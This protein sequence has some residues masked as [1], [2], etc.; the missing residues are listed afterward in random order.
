MK[1]PSSNRAVVSYRS[2][3]TRHKTGDSVSRDVKITSYGALLKELHRRGLVYALLRDHPDKPGMRDLD[4]VIDLAQRQAFVACCEQNGFRLLKSG[5]SNPGKLVMLCWNEAGPQIIDVHERMIYQGYEYLNVKT[6]LARRRQEGQY[7]FLSYEDELLALL[8]HNILGKGEIQQKHRGR[9][10]ELLRLRLDEDYLA[11]HLR[12]F[13]L[14]EILSRARKDFINLREDAKA[15]KRL[16]RA[17][18]RA[19]RFKPASNAARRVRMFLFGFWEKWLGPRR[20]ALIVFVGPDG[21]GK[22]SITSALRRE[23]RSATITTDIVY[24]GPWGQYKLPFIKILNALHIKPYRPED[25]A[26]YR[27][28]KIEL[29]T[30][31]AFSRFWRDVKGRTFYL[32]L[33]AELWFRYVVLVLPKLRR[34][35][36]VLADR[37]VYDILIGYKNRPMDYFNGIRQWICRTYPQPDLVVLLDAAPEIIHARKPQFNVPQLVDIRQRYQELGRT[38]DFHTLDTSVSVSTSLAFFRRH[39]MPKVLQSLKT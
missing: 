8:F 21:C 15:V 18:L 17:A 11:A 29:K 10:E 36:I 34:G 37:Y 13:G 14:Q 6:V 30:P 7:Y 12:E 16:R 27:N 35:R 26:K 19:L 28:R 39:L 5:R 38:L 3:A 2:R 31:G 25:K 4:L 1:R 9:L 33:A 23:F 22:S 24:L 32:A 20:G